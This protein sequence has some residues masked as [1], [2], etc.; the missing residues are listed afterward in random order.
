MLDFD[1]SMT[2]PSCDRRVF[3][4]VYAHSAA[5]REAH[6]EGTIIAQCEVHADGTVQ[7]CRALKGL[8]HLTEPT[9][10]ALEGMRCTPATVRGMP[11]SIRYVQHIGYHLAH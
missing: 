8:P 1:A 7:K 11:V 6:V 9:L 2:R 5:A 4:E 3:A 10:A